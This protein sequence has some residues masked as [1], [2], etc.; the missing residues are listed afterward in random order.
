MRCLLS[1]GCNAYENLNPLTSAE[2]DATRIFNTLLRPNIGGYDADRSQL[3]LSP[4]IAILRQ[5]IEDILFGSGQIDTFTFFFAGHGGVRAGSFYMC[6]RDSRGDALS[7][8][9]QSLSDIFRNIGEAAPAQS[10]LIIDACQSGG[11]VADLGVLLKRDVIGDA[12][13][14][15]I[16]LVATS[17][18]DQGAGET[19]E[20]GLGT[21][22]ILDCIEGRDFIN[23]SAAMLDLTE[24]GRRVSIR[25]R[26][27]KQSPV[28]WGLNLSGP[29]RFCRNLGYSADPA[30]PVRDLIHNWPQLE[31]EAVKTHFEELWSIYASINSDWNPRT[32]SSTISNAIHPLHHH[33]VALG[34]AIEHIA[35]A[36]QMRSEQADDPFRSVEVCATLA[37]CLLPYIKDK[38]VQI[39][40]QRLISSSLSEIIV[41]A[42]SFLADLECD[43]YA[44]LECRGGG[45]SDLFFLPLKISKLLGWIAAAGHSYRITGSVSKDADRV[46]AKTL[47]QILDK[48]SS[49]IQT[50][51]DVQAPY[52]ALVLSNAIILGLREEAEELAGLLF[53]SLVSCQG[54]LASRSIPTENTLSYLIARQANDYDEIQ[55]HVARPVETFTVIARAGVALDL[56]DVFDESLWKIDGL[57][58]FAFLPKK[59]S[60]FGLDVIEDGE[61]LV[62]TIGQD[63]FRIEDLVRTWPANLGRPDSAEEAAI[64]IFS[65]LLFPDRVAWFCF[66][67]IAKNSLSSSKHS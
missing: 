56:A 27:S 53:Y 23:D 13:S 51:S 50:I 55:D 19:A 26:D 47:R 18:Q 33:P 49:S 45:L 60:N 65:S 43:Q 38:S 29:S 21:N 52:W 54:Q 67:E 64:G 44:L 17:A 5:A 1:V 41:A 8:S 10:N 6:V 9:A 37:V 40:A 35:M 28:V 4:T 3:L 36:M 11:L 25:L 63:V 57:T 32:F 66:D 61:N 46:F 59:Y 48:Y 24:I 7:V 22:A 16:T 42:D 2:T 15:S 39:S 30:R 34:D 31:H 20:G 58:F 14:P 62:W 12:G